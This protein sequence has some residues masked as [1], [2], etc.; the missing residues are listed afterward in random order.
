[1]D[2]TREKIASAPDHE[3]VAWP[4]CW[5]ALWVGALAS[6]AAVLIFGLVGTALGV[7]SIAHVKDLSSW[8]S[9][10]LIDT[11]AAIFGAFLAFVIGGWVTG[12]I[13]GIRRS[14]PAILHA[15]I[16]WLLALPLLLVFLSLGA[17]EAFGGW[18]GSIIG[19]S[20]LVSAGSVISTPEAI[21][22]G[23]IAAVS[24][25]LLGLMG[26]VIGGWMA[27]GEPMSITHYRKRANHSAPRTEG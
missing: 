15:A 22:H 27:C 9:L 12:K 20:P 5:S 2:R 1:M 19:N 13:A 26:A 17:G 3:W 4:V 8:K 23:A 7:T 11:A 6:I 25:I 18:Y 10:S 14:E 16:S 21:R 24:A